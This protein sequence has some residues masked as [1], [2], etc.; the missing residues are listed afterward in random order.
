MTVHYSWQKD[1]YEHAFGWQLAG[2]IHL[3][4]SEMVTIVGHLGSFTKQQKNQNTS[5]DVCTPFAPKCKE[6]KAHAMI[7]IPS[8]L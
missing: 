5:D 4:I 8:I 1:K 6:S 7:E 2:T 3:S